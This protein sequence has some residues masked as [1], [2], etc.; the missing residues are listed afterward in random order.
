[1]LSL[2]LVGIGW[3]SWLF[4]EEMRALLGDV[5]T[6]HHRIVTCDTGDEDISRLSKSALLDEVLLLGGHSRFPDSLEL[7]DLLCQEIGDWGIQNIGEGD[8]AVRTRKIGELPNSISSRRFEEA[9][10]RVVSSSGR[11]VNL[12]TPS[13]EITIIIAGSNEGDSHPEPFV[14]RDIM[15]VWGLSIRDWSKE[16][17]SGRS[18]TERPYF[19]PVSLEPR[20]ARL[21][22]S[23]SNI[24]GREIGTVVDPFCGTGGIA[25]EAALQDIEVLASDLDSRMVKGTR[26]NLRWLEKDGIVKKWDASE[27]SKL[28]GKRQDCSFV[29]DPPYG[30]S[31]WKSDDSLEI[32]LSVLREAKKIDGRGVVSTMLPSGPDSLTLENADD[33]IVMGRKW[34]DLLGKIED[35]GWNVHLFCPVR[36]HK[37][38]V[39]V[40]VVCHPAD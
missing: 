16:D 18:P 11:E 31:S 28:W 7:Q 2:A 34:S 39:R 38:L 6:L 29:F 5:N 10:G 36:V 19:K 22:I 12:E 35:A 37:S 24:Q 1:M 17:F 3:H 8:F 9:V 26:E 4:R 30:R 25:I 32:F 20:Q 23:L 21:L 14:F 40:I 33:S 13:N 15:V 27:L